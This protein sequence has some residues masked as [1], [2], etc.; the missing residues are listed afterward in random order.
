MLTDCLAGTRVLDLSQWLPGPFAAQ[1]LADL[2]A[3]VVK[4]EPPAGDPLRRLGPIDGD[5]VSA[6]YKIVNAGKSLVFLDL[7]SEAGADALRRL[8]ARADVLVESFRPGALAKLGFGREALSGL[9]P[10]LVHCALSGYGQSGPLALKAGHDIDYMALGGG[11]A[12]SGTVERPVPAH[13]PT[14]DYASGQQA[15][16]SVLGALLRR[17]RTGEGAFLDVSL[18]ETVL[19]WQAWPMTAAL[20]PGQETDR[21]RWLLTGGAAYYRLYRTADDRFVALG[22]LEEKFWAAFCT[23]VGRDDWIARQGEPLP[24]EA[25]IAEVEALFAA[26]PLAVWTALLAEVD[27]CFEPVLAP[28]EVPE[29]PQVAVRGLVSRTGGE[30]PRIEVGFAA[31]LDGSPPSPRPPVVERSVAEALA[32]WG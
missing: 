14:A 11:L 27:C 30:D 23:A 26:R 12:T 29:H 18:M 2:G 24:Q 21:G 17:A 8:V 31:L 28:A 32:A 3:E 9:S 6:F 19:A 20:R 7:K 15:A 25:L 5:G 4:V 10:R 16:L 13:P 22:A 1:I